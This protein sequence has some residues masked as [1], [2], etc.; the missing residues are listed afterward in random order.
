[1]QLGN[2]R[3]LLKQHNLSSERVSLKV[4]ELILF[5]WKHGILDLNVMLLKLATVPLRFVHLIVVLT[6]DP[7]VS[8]MNQNCLAGALVRIV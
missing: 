8:K 1:M 3:I 6:M 7:N 2:L 4:R 5:Y